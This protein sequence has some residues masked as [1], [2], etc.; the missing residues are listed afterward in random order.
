MTWARCNCSRSLLDALTGDN[1]RGRCGRRVGDRV[2]SRT[3]TLMQ[4]NFSTA[5]HFKPKIDRHHQNQWPTLITV[6]IGS[7]AAQLVG[8]IPNL[9]LTKAFPRPHAALCSIDQSLFRGTQRPRRIPIPGTPIS[10]TGTLGKSS[11]CEQRGNHR[12]VRTGTGTWGKSSY[13]TNRKYEHPTHWRTN[14][15]SHIW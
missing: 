6:K 10:G 9:A 12:T 14:H 5:R 1:A 2:W 13:C 11:Y 3:Q 7:P 4:V 15:L 8:G